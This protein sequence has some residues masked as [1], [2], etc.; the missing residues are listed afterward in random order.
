MGGRPDEPICLWVILGE[1]FDCLTVT[2]LPGAL[3][4][5]HKTMFMRYSEMSLKEPVLVEPTSELN[6]LGAYD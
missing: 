3:T 1:L 4:P 5:Q 6:P 2:L